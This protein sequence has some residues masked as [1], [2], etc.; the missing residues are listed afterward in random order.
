MSLFFK[1]NLKARYGNNCKEHFQ[2]LTKIEAGTKTVIAQDLIVFQMLIHKNL[3]LILHSNLW[4]NILKIL[5]HSLKFP[6]QTFLSL[7]RFLTEVSNLC[8]AAYRAAYLRSLHVKEQ[9]Q[10]PRSSLVTQLHT[11]IMQNEMHYYFIHL[12]LSKHQAQLREVFYQMH[13]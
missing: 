7:L 5:K 2:S 8:S 9:E 4:K 10:T 6:A 3:I 12:N 13:C 11:D 1:I